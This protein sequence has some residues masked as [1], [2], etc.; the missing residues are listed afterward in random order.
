MFSVYLYLQVYVRLR[1]FFREFLERMSQMYE[2]RF[3]FPRDS[4]DGTCL[5]W[6]ALNKHLTYFVLPLKFQIILFTASK[7]VY[8]DKLLNILDPK[9]QLVRSVTG[10]T[11]GVSDRR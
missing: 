10:K 3:S 1:P 8:A 6:P 5:T 11:I 4:I 2:V 7:K 9:K